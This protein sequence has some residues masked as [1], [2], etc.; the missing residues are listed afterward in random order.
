MGE[1][2]SELLLDLY[3]AADDP[4]RW[5]SFLDRVC[6]DLKVGNAVVQCLSQ[7]GNQLDELWCAR[8]SVSTARRDVH[9]R[10]VNN[11]DNPRFNLTIDRSPVAQR[12]VRD[13]DRFVPGCPHYA[14]LRGRLAE[15]GL[16]DS[17]S[18]GVGEGGYRQYSLL[19][20]QEH[21]AQRPFDQEDE[22]YLLALYP[23]LE[24]ALRM[25]ER[26]MG[27]AEDAAALRRVLDALR[28]GV[29]FSQTGRVVDWANESAL[30][31][32][33]RSPHLRT[34]DRAT[35]LSCFGKAARSQHALAPH[36]AERSGVT[37]KGLGED[38]ELQV[39]ALSVG[40]VCGGVAL[41]MVEPRRVPALVAEEL[42]S[43]LGIT[44]SEGRVAAW[45]AC[46][47]TIKDYASKRGLSE[48]SVR[49]QAKQ[50]LAKSG[51]PRQSDLVRHIYASIPGLLRGSMA[52]L[53]Q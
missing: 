34:V 29:V 48:G 12:L 33:R 26:R 47:G 42:A 9:D 52:Q 17:L 7:K 14:G 3:A 40:S 21:A 49:N 2:S 6:R 19:V 32:M 35:L 36:Q 30:E 44:P 39:L 43:L 27:L 50:V 23:H 45:L 28:I 25:G 20:H 41:L 15:V 37:V 18:L 53:L 31:M 22:S 5:T 4:G 46:G 11:P 1:I 51:A 10:L 13:S 38:D 24:Q 8:D 16:G